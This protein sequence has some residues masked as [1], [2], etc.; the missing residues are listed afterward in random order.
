MNI[1][2]EN[3]AI[4][5]LGSCIYKRCSDIDQIEDFIQL[6]IQMI[7]YEEINLSGLVPDYVAKRSVEIIEQ[8]AVDYNIRN[9]KFQEIDNNDAGTLIDEVS[10]RFSS[11]LDNIPGRLVSEHDARTLLPKLNDDILKIINTITDSIKGNAYD[12]ITGDLYQQSSFSTDSSIIKIIVHEDRIFNKLV[13]LSK[14]GGWNGNMSF[15]IVS[16]LR[17]ITNRVL[18]RNNDKIYSPAVKR[19]RKEKP[20]LKAISLKIE[21]IIKNANSNAWYPES[22]EIPSIKEYL[23]N[24]G[25]SNPVEI[26][27][28]VSELRDKFAPIRNYIQ[29]IGENK[30][31]ESLGALN[32]IGNK[33]YDEIKM[34][35]PSKKRRVLENIHT[36]GTGL[37]PVPGWPE[38]PREMKL[39]V[40]ITAFT[41]IIDDM[42]I[43]S[44]EYSYKEFIKNCIAE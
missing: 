12:M 21:D 25:N 7:F 27:K 19:G 4:Q 29:E 22:I 8:L 3:N 17:I 44:S 39:D 6:C 24:K 37:V 31:I 10:K 30:I 26:L 33:L 34:G 35:K 28:I 15:Q 13:A 14:S 42:L 5:N 23:I 32:E 38:I 40:C 20:L 43:S 9:I 16:D 18:A 41:E 11:Q 1:L 2:A 36:A